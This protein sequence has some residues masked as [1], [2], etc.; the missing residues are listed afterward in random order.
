MDKIHHMKKLIQKGTSLLA[1]KV[2]ESIV[3][4]IS[5]QVGEFGIDESKFLSK[6]I[7]GFTWARDEHTDIL[8]AMNVKYHK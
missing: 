2:D 6:K 5:P 3:K 1:H 7:E 8:K 4:F